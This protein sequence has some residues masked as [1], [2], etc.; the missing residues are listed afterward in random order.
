MIKILQ[1][2]LPSFNILPSFKGKV[3]SNSTSVNATSPLERSPQTDVVAISKKQ[4]SMQETALQ[5]YEK[6]VKENILGPEINSLLEPKQDKQGKYVFDKKQIK[7]LNL[8]SK[9]I[10]FYKEISTKLAN[11]G[12]ESIDTILKQVKKVFGGEKGLGKYVNTRQKN[13]KPSAKDAVS[14]YNKIIKEFKDEYIEGNILNDLSIP[15]YGKLYKDLDKDEK[16]LLKLSLQDKDIPNNIKLKDIEQILKTRNKEVVEATDWV[17]DLIGMRLVLPDNIN[18]KEVENYLTEAILNGELDI[19]K[20]SNYHSSHIYPYISQDVLKMWQ[21]VSPG[22]IIASSS[23][24]RK[25]NGYTTTQMNI[26]FKV[27]DKNGKE[28]VLKAEL[29]IRSESLNKL[30][31]IEHLIYDILEKKNIGKNINELEEFY[32][33]TGIYNAVEE[34][35]NDPQKEN[36]YLEYEKTTYAA[37][38]ENEQKG[39]KN[40]KEIEYPLLADFGLGQYDVLSFESLDYIDKKAKKIKQKYGNKNTKLN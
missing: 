17:K 35:F 28:K 11:D 40:K 2:N 38:R 23:N 15:N 7:I 39:Q 1:Y 29:Q 4:I 14:I 34:V 20:I 36:A 13:G 16:V 37:I 27:P 31:Q 21:Q 8:A 10:D 33:S 24:I 19:T 26:N 30:G 9:K 18:M 25:K 22:I 12:N 6:V 3:Q 5:N 32:K